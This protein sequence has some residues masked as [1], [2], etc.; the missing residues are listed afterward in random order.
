MNPGF[1]GTNPRDCCVL[2]VLKRPRESVPESLKTE[3]L[4]MGDWTRSEI[5]GI[6]GY[7]DLQ[8]HDQTRKQHST[9]AREN[10]PDISSQP[11]KI[12]IQLGTETMIT[13]PKDWSSNR[14]A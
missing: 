7:R 4:R 2:R 11:S 5:C 10:R 9:V 12:P 13:L 3:N 14:K 6:Q 1:T 8:S